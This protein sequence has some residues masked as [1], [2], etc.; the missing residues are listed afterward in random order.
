VAGLARRTRPILAALAGATLLALTLAAPSG[1]AITIGADLSTPATNTNSCS[2]G[3]GDPFGC[4]W[5]NTA[6]PGRT[7]ASPI[8]GVVVTWRI[9][10]DAGS[11]PQN[12]RLRIVRPAGGTS[13]E[14]GGASTAQPISTTQALQVFPTRLPIRTGDH[15]GLD[16]ANQ[17]LDASIYREDPGA[18]QR[19]INPRLPDSGA[20]NSNPAPGGGDDL[21]V[22]NA[23]IEADADKDGFGDETQDQCPT[24]A[25][26]QGPCPSSAT[27]QC[28]DG[29]D[30]DA[31][32]AVDMA[33][34]GCLSGGDSYNAA[35]PNEGDESIRDLVLCGRR[36][37]SLVRADARG[38]KVVLRGLVSAR[39]AGRSVTI[40]ANYKPAKGSALH[41]LA[42]VK[43]NAAGQFTARVK[44][45]P[46]R[47]FN[48]ARFQARVGSSRSV[49]LKL[50]Q[51][52]A[53][54]SVRQQADTIV[55]RGKVK[56]SVL[57][58]RHPVIVRRLV[59]GHYQR[60]GQAKPDRRGNYVV[61]FKAPA[62]GAAALYRA[63]TR[64]LA[65]PG[66]KRYVRQFARAIGITLTGQTG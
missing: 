6:I 66:S 14:S 32:G 65:R 48:K 46:A 3:T 53:S 55:L 12:V 1:A 43:P 50:P 52:L 34:P 49:A 27:P 62:L 39:M 44:R 41:K 7:A 51:S 13:Y 29:V 57:G 40:L 59:C 56:R 4:T 21:V 20:A 54:S 47:L 11:D 37:I 26:T 19:I 58:K 2:N 64:V 42:T 60:V 23:D 5:F 30:N 24:N 17:S 63:E 10:P 35:D 22:V 38:G 15:I 61:R 28:G 16:Q 9:H 31:D 36:A 33:D 8:D 18:A 25:S 45:P